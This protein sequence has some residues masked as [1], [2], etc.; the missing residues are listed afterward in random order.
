MS[1]CSSTHL[2][3]YEYPGSAY[4]CQADYSTACNILVQTLLDQIVD[5][6]WSL[7]DDFYLN[8]ILADKVCE[9]LYK[10]SN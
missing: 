4:R 10:C 7:F 5:A 9:K 8:G 1:V 2:K 6:V 3:M